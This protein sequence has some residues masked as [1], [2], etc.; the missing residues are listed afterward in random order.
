MTFSNPVEVEWI[1]EKP[2]IEVK[3][4]VIYLEQDD[5]ADENGDSDK[6]GEI[7]IGKAD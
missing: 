2:V 1:G 7:V 4:S 6:T 3:F 5:N